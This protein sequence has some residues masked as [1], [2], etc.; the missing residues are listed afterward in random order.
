MNALRWMIED[1]YREV[2]VYGRI[3]SSVG[4]G[5]YTCVLDRRRRDICDAQ[6]CRKN[7]NNW[8]EEDL[9]EK[10]SYVGGAG[11]VLLALALLFVAPREWINAILALWTVIG[12]LVGISTFALFRSQS[13]SNT[14]ASYGTND[15]HSRQESERQNRQTKYLNVYHHITISKNE[16]RLGCWREIKYKRPIH[17]GSME[18]RSIDVRIPQGV[19]NGTKI[20]LRGQ[21]G[22]GVRD[23]LRG[24]L[25]LVVAVG[26][27]NNPG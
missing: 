18:I 27:L 22:T 7:W 24:D 20:R 8:N 16:A 14:G 2:R 3:C 17:T 9:I 11:A 15:T 26:D 19:T 1:Q 25:Y 23:N 4:F 6:D 10:I 5:S 12:I 21:G 13:D